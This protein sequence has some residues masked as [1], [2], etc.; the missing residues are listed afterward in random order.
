MFLQAHKDTLS[1][2]PRN[3]LSR[4]RNPPQEDSA[5]NPRRQL[6]ITP[7]VAFQPTDAGVSKG[8]EEEEI[9]Y[10]PIPK[11]ARAA[12]RQVIRNLDWSTPT[13]ED[14]EDALLERT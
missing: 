4:V 7:T 5:P 6:F 8:Q 9:E 13:K 1:L 14:A 2:S 10:V 12:I 3:A 11:R